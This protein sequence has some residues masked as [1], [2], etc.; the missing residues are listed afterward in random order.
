M[1]F[2]KILLLPFF[3][4]SIFIAAGYLM[5]KFPP[6]KINSFY[7]YRTPRS[8]KSQKNWDFAQDYS[9]RQLIVIGAIL[10][11]F[12]FL[13]YL[14]PEAYPLRML[15]EFLTLL[16]GVIVMLITC[17]NALKKFEKE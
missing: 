15:I 16:I 8:M 2:D 11:L 7:G 10:F 17:E 3:I 1:D 12:S 5:L 4:G 13:G 9:A 14:I 6:K